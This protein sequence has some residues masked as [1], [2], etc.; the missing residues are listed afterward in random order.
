[1]GVLSVL[2]NAEAKASCPVELPAE[3]IDTDGA[4]KRKVKCDSK[5]RVLFSINTDIS[6][7]AD[8]PLRAR[9]RPGKPLSELH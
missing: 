3:T 6:T 5:Q 2:Q 8:S 7:P 9:R 4:Y 1:M